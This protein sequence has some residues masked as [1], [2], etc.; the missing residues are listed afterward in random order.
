MPAPILTARSFSTNIIMMIWAAERDEAQNY[1]DFSRNQFTH[2]RRASSSSNAGKKKMFYGFVI[3]ETSEYI[4]WYLL[5]R[6][7]VWMLVKCLV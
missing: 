4:N 5:F 3:F 7:Q 2:R 1:S 6:S